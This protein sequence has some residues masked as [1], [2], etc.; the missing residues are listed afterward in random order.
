MGI[1]IL[2]STL[3]QSVRLEAGQ[4]H[5]LFQV[6]VFGSDI[7]FMLA[8]WNI[9]RP[10]VKNTTQGPQVDANLRRDYAI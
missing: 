8:E 2:C 4:S 5:R 7:L 10:V 3:N 1:V 9:K 6:T